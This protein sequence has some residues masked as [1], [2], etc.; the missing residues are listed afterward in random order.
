M[1]SGGAMVGGGARRGCVRRGTHGEGHTDVW[2][3]IT[4]RDARYLFT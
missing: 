2:E 1:A 3:K 4:E